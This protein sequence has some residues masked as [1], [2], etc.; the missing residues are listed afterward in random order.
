MSDICIYMLC[1][2]LPTPLLMHSTYNLAG[3]KT[4]EKDTV[5][6]N[7]RA[8]QVPPNLHRVKW[9]GKFS[10]ASALSRLEIERAQPPS[11]LDLESYLPH[12]PQPRRAMHRACEEPGISKERTGPR[13]NCSSYSQLLDNPL[14]IHGQLAQVGQPP[15]LKQ[16]KMSGGR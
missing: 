5:G 13:P 2:P 11:S 16:R 12:R 7:W 14:G 10:A 6:R 8:S 4:T 15:F 1:S 3:Q 9:R